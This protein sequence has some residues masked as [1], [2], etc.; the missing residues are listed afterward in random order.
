MTTLQNVLAR[1]PSSCLIELGIDDSYFMSMRLTS[2]WVRKLLQ[3]SQLVEPESPSSDVWNPT[4]RA[5][6]EDVKNPVH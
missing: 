1:S 3:V 6:W 2:A 5:R 4:P